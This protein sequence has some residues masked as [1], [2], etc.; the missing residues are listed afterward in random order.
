QSG[1]R[2]E[3]RPRPRSGGRRS[4]LPPALVAPVRGRQGLSTR[5]ERRRSERRRGRRVIQ[6][7]AVLKRAPRKKPRRGASGEPVRFVEV[8]PLVVAAGSLDA[9]PSL[10]KEQLL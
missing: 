2:A 9:A 5:G 10:S 7:Y 6:V 4:H 8:G 1:R 3:R